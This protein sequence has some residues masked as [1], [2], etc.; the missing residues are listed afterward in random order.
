MF[1]HKLQGR[2][3]LLSE[4]IFGGFV[5]KVRQRFGSL[6]RSLAD[7]VDNHKAGVSLAGKVHGS[8]VYMIAIAREIGGAENS[9]NLSIHGFFFIL[10]YIFGTNSGY[11]I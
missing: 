2:P 6:N 8:A 4:D 5:K 10:P 7:D 11:Q 3:G 9:S 1:F